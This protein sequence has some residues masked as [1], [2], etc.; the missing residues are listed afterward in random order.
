[1]YKWTDA[2][3]VVHYGDSV[4]AQYADQD[5]TILN[6]S[7][8]PVGSIPGRRTPEQV[9]AEAAQRTADDQAREAAQK[10]QQHD[11]NLLATYLSVSEIE[12]LRDRRA[13]I[14][15]GQ[16]RA[17]Q[18]YLDQLRNR[19]S[20]LEHQLMAYRPYN[21][22][23]GAPQA[24]E[25]LLETLVQVTSDIASQ[26][27]NLNSKRIELEKMRAEFTADIERFKELKRP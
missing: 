11:R 27:G 4:P 16:A 3:G 20:Q 15:E 19:Q 13:E 1:V 14:L 21:K 7:G 17:T 23:A 18:Q 22:A 24:P 10:R 8:L 9:Q 26:T 2:Q 25:P 6:R 12:S 5:K